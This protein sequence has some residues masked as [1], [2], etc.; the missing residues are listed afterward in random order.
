M[1][2]VKRELLTC[3]VMKSRCSMGAH[4]WHL[5]CHLQQPDSVPCMGMYA[6]VVTVFLLWIFGVLRCCVA[7]SGRNLLG[8]QPHRA[9]KRRVGVRKSLDSPAE[10]CLMLLCATAQLENS[11]VKEGPQC[12]AIHTPFRAPNWLP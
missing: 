12:P 3:C 5:L 7:Q 11:K 2:L 6:V 1:N 9:Q 8:S 4:Y 10:P